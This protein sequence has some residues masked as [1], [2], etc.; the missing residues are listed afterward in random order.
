M[1]P[2]MMTDSTEPLA[3]GRWLWPIA[4]PLAAAGSP[5]RPADAPK[6]AADKARRRK[7]AG[8]HKAHSQR[9]GSQNPATGCSAPSE[10]RPSMPRPS[11]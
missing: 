1:K 9:P 6:L 4:N 5:G 10:S 2:I 11:A 7:L 8:P 3:K